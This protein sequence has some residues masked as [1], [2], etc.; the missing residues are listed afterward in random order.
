M[1]GLN[2]DHMKARF[3]YDKLTNWGIV[4]KEFENTQGR[5]VN[6]RGKESEVI[7]HRQRGNP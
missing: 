6:V 7:S 4:D 3:G 1:S 2:T 5:L